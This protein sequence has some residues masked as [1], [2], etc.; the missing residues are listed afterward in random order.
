MV[1]DPASRRDWLIGHPIAGAL[2][3]GSILTG[4]FVPIF[5]LL[6]PLVGG[7]VATALVWVVA[8]LMSYW[9]IKQEG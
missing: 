3:L 5:L 6:A 9:A 2:I 1:R 7:L 8:V 4:F